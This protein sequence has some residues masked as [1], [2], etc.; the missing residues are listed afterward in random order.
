MA[1]LFFI[2]LV[3]FII[4]AFLFLDVVF[5]WMGIAASF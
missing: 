5:S 2:D 4:G 3:D 1:I